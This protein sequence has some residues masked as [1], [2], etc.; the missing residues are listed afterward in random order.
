MR[1]SESDDHGFSRQKKD[2]IVPA[3]YEPS[4]PICER[5]R[6][7]RT[8]PLAEIFMCLMA[9]GALVAAREPVAESELYY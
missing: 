9:W 3:E 2:K 7:R 4:Q 8:P 5:I 6:A 1:P